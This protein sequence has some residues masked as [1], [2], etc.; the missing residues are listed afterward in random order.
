[1]RPVTLLAGIDLGGTKIEGVVVDKADNT[2]I[3][4][5]L[6]TP[7]RSKLGY[8][9][10][11]DRIGALVGEMRKT[12]GAEFPAAIGIGTPGTLDPETGTL[13]GSNTS[14]LNGRPILTDLEA[15]L[16][17]RVEVAN[18][19]NCALAESR[20]GAGRGY[21]TVFG[22]IMGTGCGGCYVIGNRALQGRHG[23]AGEWGQLVI[24]PDG[25]LSP[26]GT[27]G[28]V[29]A[30]VAGPALE[31][32]YERTTNTRRTLRE[33]ASRIDEDAA[34]H[35]TMERLQEYFARSLAVVINTFDPHAIVVGGGVGNLDVV[36][37]Q[38]TRQRIAALIFAPR[39]EAPILKP[40]LGDSA[41]VFGAAL[42]TAD[43]GDDGQ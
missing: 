15:H 34:A 38:R 22:I 27:R 29:E 40:S 5:R 35:A 7:T 42:L 25:E 12:I 6:R 3:L 32:F 2:R 13:R 18:D 33:I 16:R 4:C 37:S 41:G 23:I 19:A 43:A 17:M 8:E 31:A 14:C 9:N 28:T 30:Y 26:H 20:L 36:Y 1:M 10:I 24:E 11:L 21:E 39:F